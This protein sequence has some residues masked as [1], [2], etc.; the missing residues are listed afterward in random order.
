M[1]ETSHVRSI[2]YLALDEPFGGHE[3]LV[4]EE[5]VLPMPLR[6]LKVSEGVRDEVRRMSG[7]SYARSITCQEHHIPE[8]IGVCW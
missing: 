8:G 2:T 7:A 1:S 4:C 3:V 6:H 5:N